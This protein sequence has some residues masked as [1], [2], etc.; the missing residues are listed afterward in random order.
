MWFSTLSRIADSQ[1][2]PPNVPFPPS[3]SI[4]GGPFFSRTSVAAAR[5]SIELRPQAFVSEFGAVKEAVRPVVY[6]STVYQ[7]VDIGSDLYRFPV[8]PQIL[9]AWGC[10]GNRLYDPMKNNTVDCSTSGGE[11]RGQIRCWTHS[12][13]FVHSRH[14]DPLRRL[15]LQ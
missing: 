3:L 1:R 9:A 10:P 7:L 13:L 2:R 14:R 15:L 5:Y 12:L 6:T 4:E 8:A 11:L